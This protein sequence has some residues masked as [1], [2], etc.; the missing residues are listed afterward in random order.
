[1]CGYT[2]RFGSLMRS[3][4]P[5]WAVY[6]VVGIALAGAVLLGIGYYLPRA[7]AGSIRDAL[8][9]IA[10]TLGVILG[11]VLVVAGVLFEQSLQAE[12][13]VRRVQPEYRSLVELKRGMLDDARRALVEHANKGSFRLEEPIFVGPSGVPSRVTFRDSIEALS[14]LVYIFSYGVATEMIEEDLEALGYSPEEVADSL[15]LSSSNALRDAE[16][17]LRLVEEA[18]EVASTSVWCTDEASDFGLFVWQK[19]GRDGVSGALARLQR[20]R[21]VLGSRL[22]GGAVL[23]PAITLVWAIVTILGA[24]GEGAAS[25]LSIWSTATIVSAFV[26]SLG[27]GVLLIRRMFGGAG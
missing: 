26:A 6:C 8:T 16:A 20:S 10:E 4:R 5:H 2:A 17:F 24:P 27:L 23:L 21:A 9:V 25:S 12:A 15:Y 22:L 19:Y 18:L 3:A 14:A 7:N 11:A 1:M 13:L